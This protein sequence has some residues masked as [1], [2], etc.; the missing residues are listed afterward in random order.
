M[1][2]DIEMR[3][4][5][6][7]DFHHHQ[8]IDDLKADRDEKVRGHHHFGMIA[9]KGH[10]ALGWDPLASATLRILQQILLNSPSRYLNSQL[11]AELRCDA[12]LPP[13]RII[14]GHAQNELTKIF[15][16]P[17]SA[18]PSRFPT[19]EQ[20]KALAVPTSKGLRSNRNQSLFSIKQSGR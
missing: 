6:A 14:P 17:G 11:P 9:D 7:A 8:D 10:P 18:D 13:G 3:E 2:S 5:P 12:G 15:G 4:A 20:F 19:P 16:N 1:G